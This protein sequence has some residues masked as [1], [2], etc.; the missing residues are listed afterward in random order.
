MGVLLSISR[1]GNA[2]EQRL[3]EQHRAETERML[4]RTRYRSRAAR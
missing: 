1:A 3:A 2:R 4:Q